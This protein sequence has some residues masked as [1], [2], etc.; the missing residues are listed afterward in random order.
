METSPTPRRPLRDQVRYYTFRTVRRVN[1]APAEQGIFRW[2]FPRSNSLLA[3]KLAGNNRNRG[4]RIQKASKKNA[5]GAQIRV[6]FRTMFMI[7]N[8]VHFS[9]RCSKYSRA[10]EERGSRRGP[11]SIFTMSKS[12]P[13]RR[14]QFTVDIITELVHR[15][16]R[17]STKPS[18]RTN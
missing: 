5:A 4:A 17:K 1:C 2:N 8:S 12:L 6:S 18:R 11:G 3:G 9:E 13:A 14:D 10:P 16:G 15:Q 7:T